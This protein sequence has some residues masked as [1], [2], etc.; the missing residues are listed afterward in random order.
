MTG[1]QPQL[2]PFWRWVCSRHAYDNPRGDFIRET[3]D[4]VRMGIDPE[5]RIDS[6]CNEAL[7]EYSR[8]SSAY[9][10]RHP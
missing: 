3:R 8:L 2:S 9:W 10:F 6:A 5:T 1:T 4:L 7:Q